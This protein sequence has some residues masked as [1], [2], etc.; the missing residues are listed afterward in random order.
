MEHVVERGLIRRSYRYI[1]HLCGVFFNAQKTRAPE[2]SARVFNLLQYASHPESAVMTVPLT[3]LD[4]S[5]AR[6]KAT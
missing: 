5:E 3:K 1:P 6:N 4:S 2:S